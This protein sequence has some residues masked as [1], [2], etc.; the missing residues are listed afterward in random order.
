MWTISQKTLK[1]TEFT[2]MIPGTVQ[3]W[4]LKN[5]LRRCR[6]HRGTTSSDNEI[7]RRHWV[8]GLLSR[9]GMTTVPIQCSLLQ[10]AEQGSK[11]ITRSNRPL[12]RIWRSCNKNSIWLAWKSFLINVTYALLL[13]VITL[14]NNIEILLVSFV[15]HIE[16]QNFLNV[17]RRCTCSLLRNNRL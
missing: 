10:P 8:L 17:P 4:P 14:N 3:T 13:R 11:V 1:A 15:H 16:L 9:V 6:G 5:F 7:D 2:G 12:S